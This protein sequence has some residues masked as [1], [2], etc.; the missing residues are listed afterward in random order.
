M[1]YTK[2]QV[3][4][5]GRYRTIKIYTDLLHMVIFKRGFDP[6]D[7][8]AETETAMFIERVFKDFDFD[9]KGGKDRERY[10]FY[11]NRLLIFYIADRDLFEKLHDYSKR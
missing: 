4:L 8:E 3:H 1:E 10:N 7:F 6:D 9:K 5:A 2:L 11:I